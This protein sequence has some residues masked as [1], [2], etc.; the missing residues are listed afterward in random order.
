MVHLVVSDIGHGSAHVQPVPHP[1][2]NADPPPELLHFC[3]AG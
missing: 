1:L 3:Y 2:L